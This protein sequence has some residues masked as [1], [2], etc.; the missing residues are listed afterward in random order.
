M[1][2]PAPC[3]GA[4]VQ[5]LARSAG[6]SLQAVARRLGRLSRLRWDREGRE[7]GLVQMERD[8]GPEAVVRCGPSEL[9]PS[10]LSAV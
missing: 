9:A 7:Q 5:S 1:R 2:A 10:R 3:V 6:Q 8:P 4:S